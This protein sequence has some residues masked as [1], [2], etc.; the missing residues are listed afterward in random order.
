MLFSKKISKLGKWSRPIHVAAF[1]KHPNWDDHI[2]DIGLSAKA[3]I[4]VKRLIYL[5]GI[6]GN[7]TS[8]SWEELKGRGQLGVFDH[9]FIFKRKKDIVAGRLWASEDAH[10]RTDYPMIVCVH[11]RKVPL[12][13][14]V[15]QVF[16]LLDGIR[17]AV[18]RTSL[19]IQVRD[20]V[21]DLERQLNKAL[22]SSKPKRGKAGGF[23]D[24][25]VE[26]A[27]L[28]ELR[29]SHEV[30]MRALYHIER[31]MNSS[32]SGFSKTKVDVPS[33]H[34]RFPATSG[35]EAMTVTRWTSLLNAKFGDK[36]PVWILI[37]N[38]QD[39]LDMIVGEP[40][41]E[42]FFCL[43]ALPGALPLATSIP[44]SIDPGFRSEFQGLIAS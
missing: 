42:L 2:E 43:R 3:F 32:A 5:R 28:R 39:W 21:A 44:Y 20:Q 25:L 41:T 33:M 16:P 30:L 35:G 37:P 17:E 1:G 10:G 13:W 9:S 22:R 14:I 23:S 34:A 19:A 15:T 40:T 4:E 11:C 27:Q 7:V 36:V 38:N 26:L 31:Q 8:G 29:S 24:S 12:D 18:S 6:G